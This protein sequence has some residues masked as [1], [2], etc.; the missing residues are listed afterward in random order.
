MAFVTFFSIALAIYLGFFYERKPSLTATINSLSPVFDV[1]RPV[2][3]LDISYG[4]INLR[5]SKKSL[6]SVDITLRNDGNEGIRIVDFD[7][8]AP[9]RVFIKDA[10][11]VDRPTLTAS[12]NYLS[13]NIQLTA[14]KNYVTLSPVIIEPDDSV[15]INFLVLGAEGI[16]PAVQVLGKIAGIRNITLR[17]A[18]S[19]SANITFWQQTVSGG[20]LVQ[21]ARAPVYFFCFI[22]MIAVI[23]TLITAI[24]SPFSRLRA[25]REKEQR[26]QQIRT[27]RSE[28]AFDQK[29]NGLADEYIENGIA[30]IARIAKDVS[31]AETRSAIY[32]L[33]DE[34]RDPETAKKHK[35]AIGP[36]LKKE[37]ID[38]LSKLRLIGVENGNPIGITELTEALRN[39]CKLI[40]RDLEDLAEQARSDYV[41]NAVEAELNRTRIAHEDQARQAKG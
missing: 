16:R 12:N 14:A 32:T 35:T 5:E 37:K 38:Y 11:I 15:T 13:Q 36:I 31:V 9:L 19:T 28:N 41:M 24:S 6:W 22:L 34:G 4:N 39:F 21:I 10:Q 30:P 26:A 40:G 18:D 33:L 7:P 25:R 17:S 2:S 27:I 23:G 3:G 29:M 20:P 1:V 8:N